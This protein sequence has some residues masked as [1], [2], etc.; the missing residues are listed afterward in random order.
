MKVSN[1]DHLAE[2]FIWR[3]EVGLTTRM[4]GMAGGSERIYVNI[5]SVPVGAYSAKYHSHSSQEEFFLVLEGS[6]T[7]RVNGAQFGVGKGD[8]IAKVAG[9]NIAHQFFNSG[10]ETLV[11]LDAGTMDDEDTCYYPDEDVY[12]H[13]SGGT[14]TAFRGQD[15]LEGWSSSP[16]ARPADP[17]W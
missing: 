6:G 4:L 10:N 11:I 15:A 1:I 12:L 16:N 14:R 7:L 8:F 3:D 2:D 5:D 17:R 13:K 9:K